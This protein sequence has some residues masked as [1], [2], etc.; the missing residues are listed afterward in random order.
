MTAMLLLFA[1]FDD[2]SETFQT[3]YKH[4]C[5]NSITMLEILS[6]HFE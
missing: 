4:D 2:E 5:K 3:K 1:L 6:I